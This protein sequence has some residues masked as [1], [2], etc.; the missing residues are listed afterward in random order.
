MSSGPR[1]HPLHLRRILGRALTGVDDANRATGECGVLRAL[2]EGDID[3]VRAAI[4]GKRDPLL[5][6]DFTA[7]IAAHIADSEQKEFF[8]Y[9]IDV[10]ARVWHEAARTG[11]VEGRS[12]RR[13]LA[14]YLVRGLEAY[15]EQRRDAH[16]AREALRAEL[17]QFRAMVEQLA[18]R[19][20]S[21]PSEALAALAEQ[22]GA[23]A[24]GIKQIQDDD[25]ASGNALVAIV[26]ALHE[27]KWIPKGLAAQ[28][29]KDGWL[30]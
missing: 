21:T 1:L 9:A 11:R 18:P 16:D 8:R 5:G 10:P 4:G 7:R 25:R 23:V 24:V 30:G 15:S 26:A 14:D 6:E 19:S 27:R 22:L 13:V 20:T 2:N 12:F 17:R 28:L 3:S 29:Q